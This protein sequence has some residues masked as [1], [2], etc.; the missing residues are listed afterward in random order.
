MTATTKK[1]EILK[2]AICGNII[3]SLEAN[4]GDLVC[5]G[6]PMELLVEKLAAQEGEEKHVP[7]LEKVTDGYNVTVG[8]VQHPME[9]A[10]Y[11]QWIE[12]IVDGERYER[13]FLKAGDSPEVKFCISGEHQDVYAREFCNI[14][15]LWRS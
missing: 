4:G 5:C 13:K 10:H 6:E 15:G 8:L 11:I 3:E 14:H 9:D 7:V 1:K 2:C 12:L